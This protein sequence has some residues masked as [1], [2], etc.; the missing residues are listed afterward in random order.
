M[1]EQ[2]VSEV[3]FKPNVL[4][5]DDEELILSSLRRL[6]RSHG[7]NLFLADSGAKALEIMA[8]NRD[9]LS[10]E[11]RPRVGQCLILPAPAV[12]P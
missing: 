8:L 3:E 1:D 6:L 5:V 7:Y 11:G 12:R 9:A 2:S 4:L 10:R